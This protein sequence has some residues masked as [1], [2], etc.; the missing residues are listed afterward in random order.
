[1]QMPIGG[2]RGDLLYSTRSV[3]EWRRL[4]RG[5]V[6]AAG[7]SLGVS[8]VW[9]TAVCCGRVG[10]RRGGRGKSVTYARVPGL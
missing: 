9:T 3:V 1:M 10:Q 6:Q 4:E 7:R 5:G 8:P 2:C